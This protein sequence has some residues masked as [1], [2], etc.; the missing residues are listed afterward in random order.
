[1]LLCRAWEI[2]RGFAEISRHWSSG[3]WKRRGWVTAKQ[4]ANTRTWKQLDKLRKR[5]AAAKKR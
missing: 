2:Q 5:G 1:M 4:V 3:G